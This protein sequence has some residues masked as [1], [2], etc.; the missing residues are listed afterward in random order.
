M[1]MDSVMTKRPSVKDGDM[2]HMQV[3]VE[4]QHEH[5]PGLVQ[6]KLHVNHENK[7][8]AWAKVP[9]NTVHCIQRSAEVVYADVRIAKTRNGFVYDQIRFPV[10]DARGKWFPLGSKD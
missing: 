2:T 3:E 4:E 6:L 1:D 9:T 5:N 10:G 8:L 7:F